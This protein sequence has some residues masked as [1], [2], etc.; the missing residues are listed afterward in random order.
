MSDDSPFGDHSA[1]APNRG[2][3]PSTETLA[4]LLT[5]EDPAVRERAAARETFSLDSIMAAQPL[6]SRDVFIRRGLAGRADASAGLLRQLS[7]PTE[8]WDIRSKVAANPST[9]AGVLAGLSDG[10]P[11]VRI[12]VAANLASPS[13]TLRKLSADTDDRVRLAVAANTSAPSD[14]IDLLSRDPSIW[15]TGAALA[16]PSIPSH[17]LSSRAVDTTLPAWV[18]RRAASNP[19][20]DPRLTSTLAERLDGLAKTVDFDPVTFAGNPSGR[21]DVTAG[22]WYRQEAQ[23]SNGNHALTPVRLAW[24]ARHAAAEVER[25]SPGIPA[26]RASVELAQDPDPEVRLVALRTKLPLRTVEDLMADQDLRVR[27]EARRPRMPPNSTRLA[28]PSAPMFRPGASEGRW[29]SALAWIPIIWVAVSL[30][31]RC[32]IGGYDWVSTAISAK[33]VAIDQS[34]TG[35]QTRVSASGGR[36]TDAHILI[37]A[38]GLG[39]ERKAVEAKPVLVRLEPLPASSASVDDG[40]S[41]SLAGTTVSGSFDEQSRTARVVITPPAFERRD[42][43][44]LF[45]W[46]IDGQLHVA[47][48]SRMVAI[49]GWGTSESAVATVLL[50]E[51][52]DAGSVF[53]A[54][55]I[56]DEA[57]PLAL[58]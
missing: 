32:A 30:L 42:V 11:A 19:R 44:F 2:I 12:A 1:A 23:R 27:T 16:N 58:E 22:E 40:P 13:A 14:A 8:R 20:L 25:N 39:P 31:S 43:G 52:P 28:R 9:P 50:P 35:S 51:S 49:V 7:D 48:S 10:P 56:D 37:A 6:W 18:L 55:Q 5:N 26:S 41:L 47:L 3:I 4:K 36:A 54:V 45:G 15:V 38:A 21:A 24:A 33:G 53:A 29:V 17:Q 46:R 57:W 34:T